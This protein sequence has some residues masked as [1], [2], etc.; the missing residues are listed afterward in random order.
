[1]F[2]KNSPSPNRIADVG[3]KVLPNQFFVFDSESTSFLKTKFNSY[4][5]WFV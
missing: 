4:K 3:I 2:G 5:K 1:M